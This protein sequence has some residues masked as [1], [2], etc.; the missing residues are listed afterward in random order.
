MMKPYHPLRGIVMRFAV[1]SSLLVVLACAQESTPN[2]SSAPAQTT[3]D[4]FATDQAVLDAFATDQAVFDAIVPDQA[5]LDAIVPDQAVLDATVPDQAV[6]DA[7][8][9]DQAVFDAVV[10]DQAVLDAVLADQAVSDAELPDQGVLDAILA[11][12]AVADMAP[13]PTCEDGIQNGEETAVDCGGACA[14]CPPIFQTVEPA[15]YVRA[16]R[17]PLKGFT[18]NGISSHEWAT[19]S[20]VYIRWNELEDDISHGIDRIIQVTEQKFGDVASRNVKVI[21]RVYLHWSRDDQKY[22]PADMATDDY[23][24]AQFQE[25]LVRLIARLGEVWDPDPRVAFVELGIFGKWGEHHS[26]D[27]EPHMQVVAAQ[28]FA[29]AF[30]NKQV[31][32]RHAWYQFTGHG[33]G[34]YWDS[35]AHYDQMYPHG[36]SVRQMNAANQ[37]YLTSYIGGEAAY[38]WGNWERQPGTNPT[39]SVRDAEHRNF[40]LNGIKWLHIS[41]LRWIHAYDDQDPETQA[42]AELVQKAMGYRFE[43]ESA[44]FTPDV[45]RGALELELSIRNVGAAPFYY[46]WPLVVAL[47]DPVDHSLVWQQNFE[48]V[49]IRDWVGGAVWP[50]PDWTPV[51]P[52]DANWSQFVAPNHWTDNPL[53]WQTPA[54]LHTVRGVFTPRVPLGQY[55]LAVGVADPANGKPNLRFATNWYLSGGWH[56][57]GTVSNDGRPAGDFPNG[58]VFDDPHTDQSINYQH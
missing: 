42:G 8:V 34:E 11:D 53:A 48:S 39:E 18:T 20:H 23:S 10:P 35:F 26:P 31:S 9:P 15:R 5:V 2:R 1:I 14:D 3:L 50:D 44:R 4:A 45:Q 25:R 21:P 37:R 27:P 47:L 29:D 52:N 56:P 12:Q 51:G 55:L 43:I 41:Q 28:A 40:V 33:F 7:I 58:F 54:P 13:Q 30:P 22:W 46:D 36:A 32:V 17:N 6:L 57:L 38:N 49:D 24:S 16:L 19:L